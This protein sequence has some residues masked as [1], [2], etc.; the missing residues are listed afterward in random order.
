LK[1][2]PQFTRL[3]NLLYENAEEDPNEVKKA[4]SV[5][6]RGMETVSTIVK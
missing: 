3:G 5:W 6:K 4:L 2:G 1:N